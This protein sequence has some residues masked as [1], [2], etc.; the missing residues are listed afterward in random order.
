MWYIEDRTDKHYCSVY[1]PTSDLPIIHMETMEL[2]L[3]SV[4]G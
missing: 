1:I 2:L 3:T 4:H